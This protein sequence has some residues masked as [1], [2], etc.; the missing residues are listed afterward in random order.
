MPVKA[1]WAMHKN[2]DRLQAES[3]LK[4]LQVMASVQNGEAYKR[5]ET[6]LTKTIG[7][8]IVIDQAQAAQ[9]EQL[10]RAGLNKLKVL[11]Q[12]MKVR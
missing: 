4:L 6:S 12:R 3:S 1:F 7:D 8:I 11:S 10:D 2:I 9:V 5:T